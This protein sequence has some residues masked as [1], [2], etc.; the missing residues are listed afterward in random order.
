MKT[1][2]NKKA[3]VNEKLKSSLRYRKLETNLDSVRMWNLSGQLVL[4]VSPRLG[5]G[6]PVTVTLHSHGRHFVHWAIFPVSLIFCVLFSFFPFGT[7]FLYPFAVLAFSLSYFLAVRE[8]RCEHVR[9]Y[10]F[11]WRFPIRTTFSSSVSYLHFLLS[12]VT[13]WFPSWFFLWLTDYREEW[14]LISTCLW[15]PL[16]FSHCLDLV[17]SILISWW[18]SRFALFNDLFLWTMLEC[19]TSVLFFFLM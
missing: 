16:A 10:P 6:S 19:L 17:A 8:V 15:D 14:C 9:L 12:Q 11:G 2:Q 1:K 4:P 3:Q 7:Y 5:L 18:I 13:V